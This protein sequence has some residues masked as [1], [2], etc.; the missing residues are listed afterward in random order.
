M[1]ARPTVAFPRWLFVLI[2]LVLGTAEGFAAPVADG[3]LTILW[4]DWGA[5]A[6]TADVTNLVKELVKPQADAF[7]VNARSLKVDPAAGTKKQLVIAYRYHGAIWALAVPASQKVGYQMLL[8]NAAN[9]KGTLQAAEVM[10]DHGY[11]KG[12][13]GDLEGAIADYDRAIELNPNSF[14]VLINRGGVRR[15]RQDFAGALADFNRAVELQPNFPLAYIDRSSVY[16]AMGDPA[17]AITDCNRAIGLDA[18]SF[19]AYTNRGSAKAALHDFG[20]AIADFNRAIALAPHEATPFVAR[21]EMKTSRGDLDGAIVDFD[22]AI[23]LDQKD[24]TAFFDRAYAKNQY[25]DTEGAEKDY[26]YA[27]DLN[28]KFT[29]AYH[30]RALIRQA[31]GDLDG[32]SDDFSREISLNPKAA[33]A[34]ADRGSIRTSKGDPAGAIADFN[35]AIKLEPKAS[36]AY[37]ARGMAQYQQSSWPGALADFR[38]SSSLGEVYATFWAFLIQAGTGQRANG[39]TELA[40]GLDHLR[41]PGTVEWPFQIGNFLLGKTTFDALL[42]QANAAKDPSTKSGDMCEA[43]FYQGMLQKIAG[44]RT[45]AMNSFRKC[46]ATGRKTFTEFGQAERELKALGA[47]GK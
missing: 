7:T 39:V 40:D 34:Y 5:N 32:A 26:T 43:W 6:R 1:T 28:T 42:T 11:Y 23:T 41:K 35:Q 30:N 15:D 3:D 24:A 14:E 19:M 38:Q 25:A 22:Q 10:Y 16:S 20:G 4:A 47:P 31:R 9:D 33:E 2:G 12:A 21:G 27:I 36:W 46:L 44:Q 17:L 45:E 13:K 8:D 29:G 37:L 18:N